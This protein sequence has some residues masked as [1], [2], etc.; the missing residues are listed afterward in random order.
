VVTIMQPTGGYFP[1]IEY[2]VDYARSTQHSI[3]GKNVTP[4]VR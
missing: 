2:D 1:A 4:T 3:F